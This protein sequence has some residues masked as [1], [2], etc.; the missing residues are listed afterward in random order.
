MSEPL[1]IHE[2]RIDELIAVEARPDFVSPDP[3]D[4]VSKSEMLTAIDTLLSTLKPKEEQI[5]RLRFGIGVDDALTL[6][7][8]GN[9]YEVTRERIRQIEAAAIRKLKHRSQI[10]AFA[11]L[12]FGGPPSTRCQEDDTDYELGGAEK[13]PETK[14][15][16]PPIMTKVA[17]TNIDAPTPARSSNIDRVLSQAAD[18]GIS[19][20]DERNGPSGRIWVNVTDASDSHCR[21]LVRKLLAL[22]FESWPG[23]GYWK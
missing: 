6:D 11:H 9:K 15:I 10:D 8:I 12:A 20:D 2:L 14:M 23:K 17:P 7:E 21:Q 22:G 4:I 18:L 1:P 19:I 3:M 16:Q 5:V 13:A